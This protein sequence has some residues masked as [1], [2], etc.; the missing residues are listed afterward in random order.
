ME[1]PKP[2]PDR[3]EAA[4]GPES[5]PLALS[6]ADMLEALA[7]VG[8]VPRRLACKDLQNGWSLFA[9]TP[10]ALREIDSNGKCWILIFDMN[11]VRRLTARL[12]ELNGND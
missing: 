7:E 10:Q 9:N 8:V 1:A 6:D 11:A 4:V 3:P 5:G 12:E 2:Q